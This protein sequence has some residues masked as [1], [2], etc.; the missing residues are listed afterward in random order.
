MKFYDVIK[1]AAHGALIRR[2]G[3]ENDRWVKLTDTNADFIDNEGN[4]RRLSAFDTLVAD[5]WAVKGQP[6]EC[7]FCGADGSIFFDAD[8]TGPRY[9]V[10]C[11]DCHARTARFRTEAEAIAAWN[12]RVRDFNDEF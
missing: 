6:R 5:D 1:K 8:E 4:V 12:G 2:G 11:P 9:Y 10:Y 3:W 7:P